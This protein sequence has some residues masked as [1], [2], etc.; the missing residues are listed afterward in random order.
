MIKVV[1]FD[2]LWI[3]DV[4]GKRREIDRLPL[5]KRRRFLELL[6]LLGEIVSAVPPE[7]DI[8][9]LYDGDRVFATAANDAIALFGIQPD[10]VNAEMLVSLLFTHEG[11]QGLLQQMEFPPVQKTGTPLED[12]QDPYAHAIASVWSFMPN[13]SLDQVKAVVDSMPWAQLEQILEARNEQA[14]AN[15]PK[16][17]SDRDWQKKSAALAEEM[18][19]DLAS[20]SMFAPPSGSLRDMMRGVRSGEPVAAS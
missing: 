17:K 2:R 18:K 11:G 6:E 14:I 12:G 16:A 3:F 5:P 7:T 15:D 19:R 13:H 20:G 9:A 8:R 10:W 1:Q 4:Q